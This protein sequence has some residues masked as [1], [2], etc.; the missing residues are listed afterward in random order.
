MPWPAQ[1]TIFKTFIKQ[2]E[3]FPVPIESLKPIIA[4]AAEEE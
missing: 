2:D 1:T 3:S 4:C